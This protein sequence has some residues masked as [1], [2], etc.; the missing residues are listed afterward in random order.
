MKLNV[1]TKKIISI[2]IGG[3]IALNAS[4]IEA[5]APTTKDVIINIII[6]NLNKVYKKNIIKDTDID[7]YYNGETNY[8]GYA[9]ISNQ[10]LSLKDREIAD[11]NIYDD[12]YDFIGMPNYDKLTCISK[13]PIYRKV[14]TYDDIL[15][16]GENKTI[17]T[18]IKNE[19]I[20]SG[21]KEKYIDPACEEYFEDKYGY[22]KI[23]QR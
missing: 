12:I 18:G 11:K 19:K 14:P 9:N 23:K 16:D 8:V 1:N 4:M 3:G 21:W 22:S 13:E 5:K 7:V 17:M 6:D 20:I 2:L 15:I 10:F